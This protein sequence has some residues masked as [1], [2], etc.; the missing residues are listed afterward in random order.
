MIIIKEIDE[1]NKLKRGKY[2][3]ET[4]YDDGQT[5]LCTTIMAIMYHN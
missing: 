5:F 1:L 3:E 2:E 4:V